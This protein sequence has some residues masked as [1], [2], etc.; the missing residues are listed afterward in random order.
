MKVLN[1][2][3]NSHHY[4][5]E[6]VKTK[7]FCPTCGHREVWQEQSEGD[8][9]VGE[10]WCCTECD[11]MWTMQGPYKVSASNE[12]GILVQ[13]KSGKLYKPTTKAGR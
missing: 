8:Y 10:N 11:S 12:V 13:L 7:C 6:Y 5:G 4:W 3:P 2:Y 9:Y 1:E